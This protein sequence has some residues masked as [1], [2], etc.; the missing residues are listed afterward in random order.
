MY[1]TKPKKKNP[2]SPYLST[3]T[4]TSGSGQST[5]E[6]KKYPMLPYESSSVLG[7]AQ[8]TTYNA[9]QTQAKNGLQPYMDV[10][11]ETT[12]KP[13]IVNPK[14][15][16]VNPKPEIVN[17][18]P[19]IVNPKPEIVNPKPEKDTFAIYKQIYNPYSFD[20]S[21]YDGAR[22]A[23]DSTYEKLKAEAE[24]TARQKKAYAD[25]RSALMYKYL[26]DTMNAMGL[27]NTGLASQAAISMDNNYNQYVMGAMSEE[28]KA[29]EDAMYNYRQALAEISSQEASA[30]Q[31]AEAQQK[32]NE[33]SLLQMAASGQYDW[34]Y[35]QYVGGMYG[36]TED[37]MNAIYNTFQTQESKTYDNLYANAFNQ[38]ATWTGTREGLI[39]EL[40]A[41]GIKPEDQVA[42]LTEFDKAATE[43]ETGEHTDKWW[44]AYDVVTT[45]TDDRDVVEKWLK[46][47]GFNEEDIASLLGYYDKAAVERETEKTENASSTILSWK[48]EAETYQGSP[49]LFEEH[50][51]SAKDLTP[52]EKEEII[53]HYNKTNPNSKTGKDY[54]FA[55]NR[56]DIVGSI[57]GGIKMGEFTLEQGQDLAYD[58]FLK[59]INDDSFDYTEADKALEKGYLTKDQHSLLKKEYNESFNYTKDFYLMNE[60]DYLPEYSAKKVLA[61]IQS[62]E[63]LT[64]ENKTKLE[65]LYYNVYPPVLKE[66]VSTVQDAKNGLIN[67]GA[68]FAVLFNS[69]TSSCVVKNGGLVESDAI[70]SAAKD[71][72]NNKIFGLNG[73]LYLKYNGA[74]YYVKPVK[75]GDLN[76]EALKQAYFK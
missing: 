24:K 71:I 57:E 17:P 56:G 43:R 26:P 28:A 64:A 66:D 53:A 7:S 25:T 31:A 34:D 29:K 49:E 22:D 33:I 39:A 59:A 12:A 23:A 5:S 16:I 13:E 75:D 19:E 52:E 72:E 1:T 67:Q 61:E 30:K 18:K 21:S 48:E 10:T 58:S 3:E 35:I 41:K 11:G 2:M 62:N 38:A 27:S 8:P 60:F 44:S 20:T 73:E 14:P 9:L 47:Q 15:E 68:V 76:W 50:V 51:N 4:D 69:N 70:K 46:D 45:T 40:T 32:Q 65:E 54:Q 37:Q 63:W 55:I 36:M 42:I 74:I 6:K